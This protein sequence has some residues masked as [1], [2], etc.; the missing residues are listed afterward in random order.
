MYARGRIMQ[1]RVAKRG[2]EL[3]EAEGRAELAPG[4]RGFVQA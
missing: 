1:A 2:G 3:T 4:E